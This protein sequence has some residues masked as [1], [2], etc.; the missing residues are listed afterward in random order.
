METKFTKGEWQAVSSKADENEE[1]IDFEFLSLKSEGE[2]I[3][4]GCGCYGS[5]FGSNAHDLDLIAAA[6][7]MYW[8]IERD[9]E[10]L[11]CR[12]MDAETSGEADSIQC[13]IDRK[14]KLLAKARGEL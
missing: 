9:I 5:P 8:E 13:D 2:E 12:I 11:S 3:I 4:G 7:E 6:P 14:S 1:G 10:S